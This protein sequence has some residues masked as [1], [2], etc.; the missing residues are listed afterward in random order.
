[1]SLGSTADPD[2]YLLNVWVT[3]AYTIYMYNIIE[4]FNTIKFLKMMKLTSWK[5]HV[6]FY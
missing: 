4:V 6:I 5:M 3:M 2:P 1:M